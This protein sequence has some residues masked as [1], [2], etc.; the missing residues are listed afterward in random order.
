FRRDRTDRSVLPRFRP[1]EQRRDRREIYLL[2]TVAVA[3][4]KPPVRHRVSDPGK[5]KPPLLRWVNVPSE[6]ETI[7]SRRFVDKG[8]VPSVNGFRQRVS[9]QR[10][11][12]GFCH[13]QFVCPSCL[14]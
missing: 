6:H 4:I 7:V 11:S 14:A 10:V 1:A 12:P 3:M 13:L 9:C 8:Y 2:V 5:Q